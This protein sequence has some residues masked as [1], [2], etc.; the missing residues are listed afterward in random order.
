MLLKRDVIATGDQLTNAT[1]TNT[2]DGPG[3]SVR[4][5][6]RAGDKMLKTTQ[7]NLNKRMGVVFIEKRRETVEIGGKK[8]KRD[9]TDEKSSTLPRSAACSATS[10]TS[11][12]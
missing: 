12:A 2:Q 3:V 7:A 8:V 10:S 9:V 1:P 4:L 6:A 5:D 11:P